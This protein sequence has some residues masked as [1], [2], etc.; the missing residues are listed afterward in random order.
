MIKQQNISIYYTI[1][2]DLI[3]NMIDHLDNTPTFWCKLF[4]LLHDHN[5]NTSTVGFTT[6][7]LILTFSDKRK[8]FPLQY[9]TSFKSQ[10]ITDMPTLYQ[11]TF[12]WAFSSSIL[13]CNMRER[14]WRQPLLN[15]SPIIG[16]FS[17]STRRQTAMRSTSSSVIGC[18]EIHN[19]SG[20][21]VKCTIFPIQAHD[22]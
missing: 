20:V 8:T 9:H 17:A 5:T 11:L 19:S 14:D 18:E 7:V 12:C 2:V 22:Q 13:A 15:T 16:W 21:Q 4:T 6:T 1:S 3:K 10:K